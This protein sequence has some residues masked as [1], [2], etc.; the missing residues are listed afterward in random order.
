LNPYLLRQFKLQVAEW[1]DICRE[2][3]EW[4]DQNL[5]NGSSP[6][7]LA[8]HAALLD[9]LEHVGRWLSATADQAGFPD[10]ATVEQI[11]M[12]LRDIRDTRAMWHGKTS[13]ELR[14]HILRGCFDES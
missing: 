9:E 13:E 5:V 1:Q 2:L 7:K 14:R 8:E 4:E 6:Q 10:K 3:A 12:T 11:E